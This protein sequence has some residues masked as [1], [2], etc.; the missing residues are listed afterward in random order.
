MCFSLKYLH[1][2]LNVNILQNLFLSKLIQSSFLF[3]YIT[4]LGR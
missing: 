2:F 3:A 1:L 4:N